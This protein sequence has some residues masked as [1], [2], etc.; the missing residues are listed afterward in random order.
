MPPAASISKVRLR[1]YR[2]GHAMYWFWSE[3]MDTATM[4]P[5]KCSE[6][7][8]AP[9][10]HSCT[11]L[12]HCCLLNS[13]CARCHHECGR[14]I[15]RT[16]LLD[17]PRAIQPRRICGRGLRRP[18]GPSGI[19]T[20]HSHWPPAWRWPLPGRCSRGSCCMSTGP[21]RRVLPASSP[22]TS[23]SFASPRQ[24]QYLRAHA[25]LE[26][27]FRERLQLLRPETRAK[28]EADLTD[29]S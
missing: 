2:K 16:A 7:R 10:R 13:D 3:F 20:G 21:S 8:P 23:V 24:P 12:V 6:S 14:Q 19:R 26:R 22:V 9:P 1:G 15:T 5:R 4:R 18:S 25:Q 11:A 17:L 29:H 28:I 27:L